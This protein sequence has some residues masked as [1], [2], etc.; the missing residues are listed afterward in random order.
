[1]KNLWLLLK[2]YPTK[3]ISEELLRKA[4]KVFS[5]KAAVKNLENLQEKKVSVKLLQYFSINRAAP[6]MFS[7]GFFGLF[8]R[9]MLSNN[10]DHS[11]STHAKI[12]EKVTFI[13]PWY[14]PGTTVFSCKSWLS[15][16]AWKVTKYGV[17]AG[18][19]FLVFSHNTGKYGPEKTSYLTGFTQWQPGL[20]EQSV[21]G[22]W[23]DRE[24]T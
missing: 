17:F 23:C 24:S 2:I 3:D 1:M 7:S 20:V 18:L 14:S 22:H 15:K 6:R 11:F 12:S 9:Y 8:W 13:S 10:R 19:Y 21:Q 16:T 4:P 5:K